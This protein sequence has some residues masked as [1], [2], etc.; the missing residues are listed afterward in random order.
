VRILALSDIHN[1]WGRFVPGELPPADLVLVAGDLTEWGLKREAFQVE[2]A[3][4][5]LAAMGCR[6]PDV[7]WI[8]GNHDIGVGPE[9]FCVPP[10]VQCILD[11]TVSIP[12]AEASG[13]L[14]TVHGV[15][16]S[17]AYDLPELVTRFDYTTIDPVQE[18]RAY[19]FGPVDIV[20][21]HCPPYQTLDLWLGDDE[22]EPRHI[23]SSALAYRIAEDAPRLVVCGHVHEGQGCVRLGTT[24]VYNVARTWAL[25]EL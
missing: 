10:N 13:G 4:D 8:P 21:S 9:T 22:Q 17:P 6:Y 7:L 23:G 11:R 5:W 18:A 25:I 24:R 15:S 14:I 12:S 3:S 2:W 16:L 19:G 20:L 1:D